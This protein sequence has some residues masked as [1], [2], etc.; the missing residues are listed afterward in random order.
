MKTS[1]RQPFSAPRPNPFRYTHMK[2]IIDPVNTNE[3]TKNVPIELVDSWVAELCTRYHSDPDLYNYFLEKKGLTKE[4]QDELIPL[5]SLC[6]KLA[7]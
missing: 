2:N 3:F 1:N 6:R 5:A 7:S 4:I